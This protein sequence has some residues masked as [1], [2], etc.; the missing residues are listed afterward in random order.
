MGKKR[1]KKG[2]NG[3]SS[4]ANGSEATMALRALTA[5]EVKEQVGQVAPW[6]YDSDDGG[7]IVRDVELSSFSKALEFINSVGEIAEEMDH[8][9]EIYNVYNKVSFALMTHSV[10][11]IS[12]LDF[13]LARR[14]EE[15]L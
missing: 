2:K 15:I 11:G 10:D 7:R 13:E 9:P 1:K 5:G 8:H 12:R 6:A 3:A 4:K 14:I